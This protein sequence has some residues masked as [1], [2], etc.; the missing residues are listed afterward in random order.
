MK[1][2]FFLFNIETYGEFFSGITPKSQANNKKLNFDGT[3][4]K[5]TLDS[6]NRPSLTFF[7]PKCYKIHQGVM[8]Q[9]QYENYALFWKLFPMHQMYMHR[10]Y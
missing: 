8:L 9:L 5:L 7:T 10:G 6:H 4:L 1:A 2:D 3:M